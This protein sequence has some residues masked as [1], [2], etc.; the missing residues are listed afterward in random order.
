MKRKISIALTS[1]NNLVGKTLKSKKVK[2]INY[3]VFKWCYI[4]FG[5]CR[6]FLSACQLRQAHTSMALSVKE[7]APR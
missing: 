4:I 6:L 1:K 3:L 5:F 7:A 2:Y